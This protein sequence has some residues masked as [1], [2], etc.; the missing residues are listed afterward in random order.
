MSN[1]EHIPEVVRLPQLEIPSLVQLDDKTVTYS[2]IGHPGLTR[3]AVYH[4]GVPGSRRE[5]AFL[6]RAALEQGVSILS[7]DRPGIGG[8]SPAS[9]FTPSDWPALVKAMV[10]SLG[11]EKFT[12]IGVSGGAPYALAVAATLS[13]QVSQLLL[14]SGVAPLKAP[15]A[16]HNVVLPNRL[17]L[18]TVEAVPKSASLIAR[19][20]RTLFLSDTSAFIKGMTLGLGKDDRAKFKAP[21][22]KELF[23][24]NFGEHFTN[25]ATTF[26][27]ELRTLTRW[28]IPHVPESVPATLWHGDDDRIVS[29]AMAQYL[30]E[31]ISHSRLTIIPGKGHLVVADL[32]EELCSL[33]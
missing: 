21:G 30:H 9:T 28:Q 29:V 5:A 24:L 18:R 32:A 11:I 4:H 1:L 27:R 20:I 31:K 23:A 7:I 33:I 6:H 25:D 15:N 14:I 12:I 26:A 10:Q 3:C 17:G 19:L 22:V 2:I 13:Q 16:L 8:S